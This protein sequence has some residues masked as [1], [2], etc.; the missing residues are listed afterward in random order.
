MLSRG[1]WLLLEKKEVIHA[2]EPSYEETALLPQTVGGGSGQVLPQLFFQA[3]PSIYHRGI[4][5]EKRKD[6]Q[7]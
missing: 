6:S 7:K 1:I 4:S 5:R 2:S 3:W